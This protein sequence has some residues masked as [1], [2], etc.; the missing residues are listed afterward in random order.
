MNTNRKILIGAVIV[1]LIIVIGGFAYI[2]THKKAAPVAP[3]NTNLPFGSGGDASL[4]PAEIT[5]P[6]TSDVGGQIKS[7]NNLRQVT[8]AAVSGS[9]YIP[10]QT[11]SASP[12][13]IYM[14]RATGHVF[15]ANLDDNT[16]TRITNTTIPKVATMIWGT[17][18]K[19]AGIQSISGDAVQTETITVTASTTGDAVLT[20][21]PFIPGILTLTISPKEDRIFYILHGALGAEGYVSDVKGD[22]AVRV[23]QFPTDEW[24]AQWGSGDIV[25]LTSNASNED[26]GYL[27]SVNVKTKTQTLLLSDIPALQTKVS[28]DGTK[29]FYSTVTG[30]TVKDYL[31][32]VKSKTSASLDVKTL[33]SKCGWLSDDS[34]IYCGV[35][36][37]MSSHAPDDWFTGV[38]SYDDDLYSVSLEDG[39]VTKVQTLATSDNTGIDVTDVHVSQDGKT[40][41]FMNKKDLSLWVANTSN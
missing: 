3:P 25:Y 36:R 19:V 14:E 16:V 8:D 38:V 37:V 23:F 35:P 9:A 27:Y 40:V 33:A 30:S 31:Y 20:E 6:Q 4:R 7:V 2:L 28:P 10:S 22:N 41:L 5:S 18:G 11:A 1:T 39:A 26:A 34:L 13:V 12:L 21:T 17:S 32:D 29:I 24:H 15:T